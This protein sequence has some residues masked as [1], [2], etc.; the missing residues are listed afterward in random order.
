MSVNETAHTLA[1]Y[2]SICQDNGLVPIIEPEILIDGD[3][4]IDRCAEV[5]EHVFATVMKALIDQKLVLEGTLLK[6]N[7]VTPGAACA[8]RKSA[9]EIA[10]YTVRTLSRSIVPALCGVTFL[11]GGQSE[12]EA[13]LNLNAM[14]KITEINRPWAL[15]FS[16][17][18][19]LQQ[20]VLRAWGGKAEN[21]EAA[22]KALL[23]RAT[24]NG[25][26]AKGEYA[27]G[28]GSKES[29]FVAN[30]SY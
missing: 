28:S 12:E 4:D 6:P 2:G 16:Y 18:R 5:S 13:S 26:A 30:Y 1:R 27:G 3:H 19:A 24:A 10:W 20:S 25:N 7:M 17:G 14:N 15:T 11:S 21:K 23:E 9:E 29:T 8:D 22:Q